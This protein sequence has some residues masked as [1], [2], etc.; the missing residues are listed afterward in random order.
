MTGSAL[1]FLHHQQTWVDR[2]VRWLHVRQ[3]EVDTDEA[4]E[5][6]LVKYQDSVH[7]E[8]ELLIDMA[9]IGV[10][11]L[12]PEDALPSAC[13]LHLRQLQRQGGGPKLSWHARQRVH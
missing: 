12:E 3:P 13:A 11:M 10:G 7:W 5:L 9:L 6:A 4:V 8:P 2:F 1:D